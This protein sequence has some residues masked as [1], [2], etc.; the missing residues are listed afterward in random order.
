MKKFNKTIRIFLALGVCAAGLVQAKFIATN[1]DDQIQ[2]ALGKYIYTIICVADQHQQSADIIRTMKR[3]FRIAS[4]S[5]LYKDLLKKD[6]CF[7]WIEMNDKNAAEIKTILNMEYIP[8]SALF[9]QAK[10]L[11]DLQLSEHVSSLT[12]L[13]ILQDNLQH[14]IKDLQE[15]REEEEAIAAQQR[16]DQEARYGFEPYYAYYYDPSWYNGPYWGA[17]GWAGGRAAWGSNR[18]YW[19][20][21]AGNAGGSSNHQSGGHKK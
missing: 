3:D 2:E 10:K 6:I 14:E 5:R 12:F 13:D 1:H 4:Q 15:K 7:L 11:V 19:N 16:I 20:N 8:G 21:R 9:A 18:V 17:W